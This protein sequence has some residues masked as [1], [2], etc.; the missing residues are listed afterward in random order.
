MGV[1]A[2]SLVL[3][4]LLLTLG[5]GTARAASPDR[6]GL[7]K[8]LDAVVASGVP[9]A[10]ALVRADGKTVRLG[11][12]D[13]RISPRRPIRPNDRFRVGSVTKTFLSTVVLQLV[14]EKRLSLADPVEKLLPGLVPNGRHI[15]VHELLDMTSGLFDYFDDPRVVK[16][17]LAG[18]FGYY[19][20]PERLVGIG[21]SHKPHYAPGT[22]WS[23]CNTCYIILGLVVEKVTGHKVGNELARRIFE[24]LHLDATSFD[25]QQ[26]IAGTH[27]HGYYRLGAGLVD[28]TLISPSA[29]WAAGAIVSTADDL[30]AFFRALYGGRLLRPDLL[31]AM[32]TPP[33]T[34]D[35]NEL[36]GFGLAKVQLPCGTMFGNHGDIVG[37]GTDTWGSADGKRFFVLFVNVDEESLTAKSQAMMNE[38]RLAAFCGH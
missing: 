9:G 21:V 11:S 35:P 10:L 16:P 7:Q 12:G 23:Y 24:P 4:L 36:Y 18:N 28:T 3:A 2:H 20:S 32:M 38:F 25:T 14:A 34:A 31:R 26:Q 22:G 29:G 5:S 8:K 17:W 37:F 13:A 30:S 6:S 33:P 19:W 27:A 1:R 15:T